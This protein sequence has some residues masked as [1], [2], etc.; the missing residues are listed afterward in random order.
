M[1]LLDHGALSMAPRERRGFPA[2]PCS[3][4]ARIGQSGRLSPEQQDARCS[5][6]AAISSISWMRQ[7]DALHIRAL[8][9]AIP[10]E[11]QQLLD[12]RH[13]EAEIARPPHE[14][15]H[16]HIGR[17][18]IAVTGCRPARLW[19]QAALL[20]VADHLGADARSARRLANVHAALLS[21][22]ADAPVDPV[23][24]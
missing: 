8:P 13:R 6:V 4:S 17:G 11:L 10:P 5:S 9:A 16:V 22:A 24:C 14:T 2:S 21:R 12:L 20:I 15:Q 7:R 1:V 3:R 23:S 19:N 18:V